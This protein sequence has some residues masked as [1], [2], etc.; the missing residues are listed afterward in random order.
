MLVSGYALLHDDTAPAASAALRR[1]EARY[2]ALLLAAPDLLRT[3]GPDEVRRRAEGADVLLANAEEATA[4][5]GLDPDEAVAELARTYGL[6]CITSGADGAVAAT[7][8]GVLVRARPTAV[9]PHD[10]T[11]AGDAFAGMFLVSLVRGATLQQALDA[12]CHP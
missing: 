7:A 2:T 3:L 12:A 8:D 1:A 4:L 10:V 11:G 5:T 9:L 6:A